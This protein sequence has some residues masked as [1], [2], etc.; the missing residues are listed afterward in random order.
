MILAME[1]TTLE[2]GLHVRTSKHR[3]QSSED[4]RIVPS[5]NRVEEKARHRFVF[6]FKT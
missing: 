6:L 3:E 1:Q 5:T 4:A 2:H